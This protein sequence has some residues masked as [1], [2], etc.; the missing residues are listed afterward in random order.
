MVNFKLGET[1]VKTKWSEFHER[2]TKKKSESPTGFEPLTPTQIF[3]LSH[4]RD[5][6]IISF[7]FKAELNLYKTLRVL[8]I[9]CGE[10]LCEDIYCF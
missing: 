7:S 5:M 1:N 9:H 6:L 8:W 2:E 10:S 3:S 4:V